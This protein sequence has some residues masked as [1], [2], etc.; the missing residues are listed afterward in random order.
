[1]RPVLSEEG[2][3]TTGEIAYVIKPGILKQIAERAKN[4]PDHE[5]ALFID[6]I[7]RANVSE[8]FGELITLIED[9]K[10]LGNSN[11]IETKLP[12]SGEIFGIPNNLLII[13]TMNTADHSVEA[14]DTA[15]RRRFSFVEMKP[16]PEI[17][18]SP[19]FA[20]E[21]I[22]L[23][24]LLSVINS[25]IAR[26]LTKDHLIG[27][28]FFAYLS[29]EDI[30]EKLRSIFINK[31]IPLLQEYFYDDWSKIGLV[32]G[33]KFIESYDDNISFARFE[34]AAF[35]AFEDK[36]LYRVTDPKNWNLETYKS[37]YESE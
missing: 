37:I 15:L 7:N 30:E 26:L 6:E 17:L 8:V 10:R 13:G 33:K 2:T 21:N 27:H 9:D 22:D 29:D 28:G 32:L 20:V 4:D 19:S 34:D 14:L 31:I 5:Y 12:Y 24:R 36:Q 16:D 35:D 11:S 25:R 23:E 1:L 3:E 18:S